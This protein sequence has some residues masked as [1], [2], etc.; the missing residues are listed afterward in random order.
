MLI[1][2]N[3][4]IFFYLLFNTQYA[5][6]TLIIGVLPLIQV[7]YLF[8]YVD[9]TN[10]LLAKAFESI[11]YDNFSEQLT[12]QLSDASFKPLCNELNRIVEKFQRNRLEK[13]Q[14]FQYLKAIIHQAGMGL[15]SIRE[16]GRINLINKAARMMLKM[17]PV[18]HISQIESE[19]KG[20]VTLLSQMQTN[21]KAFFDFVDGNGSYQLAVYTSEVRSKGEYY[22][23]IT[24]QN[25]QNELEEKEMEAWKKLTRVLSHEIMNSITPIS[26]LAAT[27]NILVKE[28]EADNPSDSRDLQQALLTIEKRSQGLIQFVKNYRQFAQIPAPNFQILTIVDLMKRIENLIQSKLQQHSIELEIGSVPDNL[29]IKADTNLVEQVLLNLMSNAIEAVKQKNNP[30]VQIKAGTNES[31]RV[32]VQVID[33]GCGIEEHTLPKVFI[34]FFTTKPDGSGIGLSISRQIMRMHGGTIRIDSEAG[35]KTTA[36]LIF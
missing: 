24:I 6:T 12:T 27:A 8:R 20:F 14:Q 28:M 15:I 4:Y 10:R 33:N 25:I 35:R 13:E 1:T 17:P 22:K 26:S 30:C 7:A 21:E 32:M 9:K 36:S 18:N 3:L 29:Q 19:N 5:A 2:V 31:S 11:K 34:P 23:L 16:S